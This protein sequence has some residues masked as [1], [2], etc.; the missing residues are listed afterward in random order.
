MMT[1]TATRPPVRDDILAYSLWQMNE[2]CKERER[3][4]ALRRNSM[5]RA[6]PKGW[7]KWPTV[8]AFAFSAMFMSRDAF[9]AL[10]VEWIV[11][12]GN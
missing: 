9:A 4:M 10:L 5:L 11:R 12:A 7:W 3:R 6:L 2:E 1:S 8:W